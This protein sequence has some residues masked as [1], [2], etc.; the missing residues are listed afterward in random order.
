M[1]VLDSG[2]TIPVIIYNVSQSDT[3][4]NLILAVANTTQTLQFSFQI[5]P[6]TVSTTFVSST[7][8]NIESESASFS[9]IYQS[10][11][12]PV[13]AQ[14]LNAMGSQGV[15]LPR[16]KGFSFLYNN[17]TITIEDGYINVLTDVQYATDSGVQYL[18]SKQLATTTPTAQWKPFYN[19]SIRKYNPTKNLKKKS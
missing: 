3:L 5:I 12:E 11:L 4:E 13:F 17:S 14:T 8:P 16:I 19:K 18:M 6:S 1:N 7:I 10:S 15:P 2:N 9:F